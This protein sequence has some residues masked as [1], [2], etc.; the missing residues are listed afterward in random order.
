M[1]YADYTL[2]HQELLGEVLDDQLAYWRDALSGAPQELDLP[3][4]RP[5]PAVAGHQGGV[6]HFDLDAELHAQLDDLARRH[7]VTLFIVLQAGLA[8]LLSRLGAGSDIPLGTV[9]AG[10]SDEALDDLVGFFVNTLVLR[11]DVSGDPAFGE[12]LT[13]VRE[14]DLAAFAHQDVPFERLVEEIN[15]DRAAARHPLFQTMLVMENNAEGRLELPGVTAEPQWVDETRAKFDL[16]FTFTEERSSAGHPMGIRGELLF[17]TELFDRSSAQSM[18]DRLARLLTRAAADPAVPISSF[19]LLNAGEQRRIMSVWN[20]TDRVAPGVL[21]RALHEVFEEQAKRAPDATA[22]IFED[23]RVTYAELNERADRLV[24][25]LVDAGAVVGVRLERGVDMVVALLAV[26]KA[27]GGYTLLDPEFPAE[28]V[29]G[30]LAEAGVRTVL[31]RTGLS[32]ALT[33]FDVSAVCVDALPD[34]P[35]NTVVRDVCADDVAC[36]MFTSGSTGRPKGVATSHRALLGTYLG[37][38]YAD[39]GPDE[40]FLQCSP[41]S[42]DGFALELFGALLH[43]ATCVLQPGQSPEPIGIE[44]LVAEH[45]V[46]MLQLSA[47]LFNHL[48]DEYPDAFR[49]VRIAFTGGEAGSVAHVAKILQLFPDLHVGNGYGPVESMGFTTCHTITTDDLTG[50]QLPIGRPIGNKRAYV[51]DSGLHLL[52]AG[53]VGE[54]YVA[55]A[56]LAR[57]YVNRAGLTAER[58]VACPFGAPGERMYRTGDLA[59][60]TADGVLE[61]IGRADS[62][63][64][65]RGFRIEPGEIAATLTG[66]ESVVQAAVTAR[67]DQP[68]DVRLVAYAVPAEQQ[69]P[70]PAELRRYIAALL[71]RHMVPA[72][73]VL[74]DA[75]PLTSNGKLDSRALPAPQYAASAEGRQ[76]RTEQEQTLTGLFTEIL[77]VQDI[78]VDDSFFDLGGHSLLATR[79]ISRIR[80]TLGTELGIRDLFDAPTVAGLVQRLDGAATARTP[81]RIAERPDTLP[82]SSAQHRLWFLE[83]FEKQATYNAPFAYRLHGQVNLPALQAAI[84]D[85]I[86]RHEALRTTFPT[87]NGQPRQHILDMDA[88]YVNLAV[89]ECTE[90]QLAERI[91]ETAFTPFD[92]ESEVP[93]RATLLTLSNTTEPEPEPESVLVLALHHIASDG[94]SERPL[95]NDLTTAY[96]ARSTGNPPDWQ[97]LPVQYA[98]YTLWQRELLDEVL[99]DQLAYWAE[100]LSGA[101]QELALP[102]DR[103]RPAVAGHEGGLVEFALDA[104]LHTRLDDLAR[105][106]GATLFMVLQAALATLLSRMGAGSDIPLGTVVAGRSDEALDDLVGFFVNTLV[107]RTDTSGNPAFTELL[108]RVRDTDLGAFA[109]QDIP[110]ERLVEEINPDRTSSRHPLFQTMLVLQNNTEGELDLPGLTVEAEPFG[111]VP[112]KFDLDFTFVEDRNSSG[113]P[114]GIRGTVLFATSLFDRATAQLMADRLQLALEAATADPDSPI[115]SLQLFESVEAERACLARAEQTRSA[116][117]VAEAEDEAKAERSERPGARGPRSAQE[118]ILCGLFAEVLDTPVVGTDDNFFALG[119]HSLLA[120]RLISRIRTVLGAELGIRDLFRNPTVSGVAQRL[121]TATDDTR[122]ALTARVRPEVLPL[123]SAQHRLWFLERFE[124]QATYNAP[125]AYRLHGHIDVQALQAAVTDVVTRH[126][127][128]R[129]TFPTV[130]GEPQ[131]LVLDTE[132]LHVDFTVLECTEEQLAERIA[133]AAFAAFDLTTAI[134]IRIALLR[135]SESESMLVL[136]LHHIASD[137]WSERSLFEDLATAYRA[138]CAGEAPA[139]EPLPVQYADYTLWHEELLGEVLD[140]QLAYWRRTVS[141]MPQ[142]LDIPTDRPRP[143]VASH[144]GGLVEF[145][146]D[147]GLHA[148]LESLAR[149]HGV[150][151]FMVLQAGLAALLSRLGAGTDIPLGTVVAG[152]SDEALDDLVGFFVNTLVLRTDVSGDPAFTELLTRIRD[153]DLAAFTHQDIPFE[154]LVEEINPERS[155][156]RHPLFQVMLVLQNNAEG[157]IELDGLTVESESVGSIPAKFDLNFAFVEQ[158]DAAGLP[159]GIRGELLFAT[160]L[161]DQSSAQAMAD[162]LV[163]LLTG[164]ATDPEA[165]V[166]SA[167]LLG[168]D[169]RNTI[170]SVWNDTDRVAPG[171]LDRTLHEVFEEQARHAP[172]AVALVFGDERVT[173]AELNER[174]DRLVPWLVDAGAVIGIHLER[175]VDMVAALLAT[176][177]AGSGYT[178]LDPEFPAERVASVLSEADVPLVITRIGLHEAVSA[179]GTATVC[180]DALT[181]RPGTARIRDVCADDVACVMFTSGSTGRPKGVATS[182]G[183]LLGTYL[184]QDYADFGPDE[185]FLQCSPVSWDGF[186]LELFGALLHGATCVLQPGQSP[187]PIG[188]ERLVAEHGV[189]MLQLSASLFNHLVDEYPDAFRGVRIAFTGGEAGSVAHV[190]KILQLFPDLHVG[191]G[192]GPVES[193]GFTTCHTITTDDL[194]ASRLPIGRPVGNKRAYVLDSRLHPV[195]AGVVGEVYVAGAGLARGYVSRPGLTAERFVACPFGA[196]GERMYRTGDLARWTTDGTLEYIGRADDQIK[197]RGFR[198]EPGEIA[199]A[200]TGHEAV[201]QAAVIA[202]EDRPGDV[203]LVAYAVPAGH[204]TP[205]PEELRRYTAALLPRHMVPSAVVLLDALPLTSNGKLDRHALPAPEVR[206]EVGGRGPRSVREE[207]LCGIFAEVLSIPAVGVDDDFFVLGGHSLLA[208]R[209]ISR[210]RTTL[211]AELGIRDLFD[212]PTVAG[213]VQRLDGAAT[214]RTALRPTERP[215]TLPLSSAQHRLWFLERFEKQATYNAPFAYRLHGH[216]DLPALQA[217]INDVITRHEALRTTFPTTNGQPRQHVLSP[218]EAHLDLTVAECTEEQLAER[219]S[220]TAFTQFDLETEI[221]LRATLLTLSN[222]T[223]PEPEPESVLVLALHHIASD[224]WSERPLLNDLTTAYQARS[225]GNPPDWQPLPVQYADY[226]LWQRDLLTEIVDDQLA[227]WTKTLSGAPQELALP[228]DRPRPAA[229]SHE[230]GLV[231]FA[232]DADLHTRLDDLARRQGVTLF[233]V[234]QAGLAALLTRLGAGTDIPLGT[235]VAGRTDEALDDLVGFFVNTLVLRTDTSGNPAF[236]ELLARVRDTDLGA[237]AHQ[238]IPFERLVE[239]INPDRA[240]SRHPLFQTM[241][242]L[243]NNTEGTIGLDGLTLEAEPFGVGAPKFDLDFTFSEGRDSAGAPTGISGSVAFAADLFDRATARSM[244][245]RLRLILEGAAAD[246]DSPIGAV[247]LLGAG[248]RDR[249][250]T[251]WND[252]AR[253]LP[254]ARLLP[255]VFEGHARRAPGATALVADGTAVTFVELNARANRL[256]RLLLGTGVGPGDPVAVLLPRS[257]ELVVALLAVM[258]AGACYVPVDPEYPADRIG[259]M[260]ADAVP[261]VLLTDVRGAERLTPVPGEPTV[262][263]RL[264]H[265]SVRGAVSRQ[266]DGN[267]APGER[268]APLR[269]GDPAYIVYTS[270]STGRPKGVLVEHRA[271]TNLFHQH[272]GAVYADA[273]AVPGGRPLRAALTGATTFDAAWSPLLWMVAGHEL[274]LVDDETRRSP[275]ALVAY[276]A[277]A[278]IDYME[279]TPTYCRQLL[280]LGLLADDRPS[281]PSFL[282]IGG[283]AVDEALWSELGRASGT[284]TYNT[285]GPTECTVYT[286]YARVGGHERPV[287]GRPLGNHRAYVLDAGLGVVPAGVV[288][289]LYIAGAGLARGYVNR[290]GLTAERFVACPFGAPG[291]RM[292]RTGDL[293]RWTTDGVLEYIGRAD[294]QIKIRGFRIEPGEIAAALTGHQAVVQAAVIAREDRPGDVRLV[295]YAVPGQDTAPAVGAADL[296]RYLSG[297]LPRHMVPGAVVVLDALPM[298]PHGKLDH[299]ALPAPEAGGEPGGRGPRTVEERVLCEVFAEVL[300]IPAVGIDDDFFLL[301]GHS[302]KAAQLVS[303]ARTALGAE[304]GIRDLFDAPTVAGLAERL[305]AGGAV[306]SAHDPLSVLLPLRKGTNG[307]DDGGTAS[308]PLFCIHPAAGISWVYSGLLRHLDRSR[309]VYGLQARGLTDEA[310]APRSIEEMAEDYLA[311]IRSVQ[312]H[313]PYAL[314][315]WSF[316]GI[317]AHELAV[318]LQEEGEEVSALVLMDSYPNG[319]AGA[320]GALGAPSTPAAPAATGPDLPGLQDPRDPA[321]VRAVFESLGH[322]PD[323]AAEPGSPLALLGAGKL[324]AVTRVFTENAAMQDAF[325]PRTF[326]GD[327]LL[328]EATEGKP[329]GALRPDAWAA[330]V[331][332]RVHV[333]QVAGL[334]GELTRPVH[335]AGIGPVVAAWCGGE[336]QA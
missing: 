26:L 28:R 53:V 73:I 69:N 306:G 291:E 12:L 151:L 215:D 155:A 97:P 178:L 139:W 31:T 210:I 65:I 72:A 162:R 258:K 70:D 220:E 312:P 250:V 300:S 82:L 157:S 243:Q 229:P 222:T 310:A 267:L 283:E 152:R 294:D 96:Q 6:V 29:A 216:I 224:G 183:A 39:F 15:P 127:A 236:T 40:V 20:D 86:T 112:S 109:H 110:F 18:A 168:A 280:E 64:K 245:D 272:V 321:A 147:A 156:A 145:E 275:E 3:T 223:E 66:H 268:A 197:I 153:T 214:A 32:D 33:R 83:R 118:E 290:P 205:G 119:G 261:S 54:L 297:L 336:G 193:M 135:L 113:I 259:L 131:Q 58:F 277:A 295:A 56:G 128:L 199:A 55:G 102:T 1:Q 263:L 7:G 78:T 75:L 107:L 316:G 22:L 81:L 136:T 123:S 140:D 323:A 194:A 185:V 198:I 89:A 71:P 292:Y 307:G 203:R 37:Q 60:W 92:L 47:S 239:A 80:T 95:L 322:D 320:P 98:D 207:I 100:E 196:P 30:V 260:L 172:D 204:H 234:L 309:A 10:R 190:A 143:P 201:V 318:R 237:F 265:P 279:M 225:T 141:G 34:K 255:E 188:I 254:D 114:I 63:V 240:G 94:W 51:V 221:P 273:P 331:T 332:G 333:H 226:T 117:A 202:R 48:V 233:M 299:R 324:E 103:P 184:G 329:E 19:S 23:L 106:H 282:E 17:A 304:I 287:I 8:A 146:L 182:H 284:V 298:T 281:R 45:G 116:L 180:V 170:V 186:A 16:N 211:G 13:R 314:L 25:W 206:G 49:G 167:E 59:R 266:P 165:T 2:W 176:L 270:G 317:V 74:L 159:S 164:A 251:G 132:N 105:R 42:W 142:E 256:A 302:L 38:D 87:T 218:Q 271:L 154:R 208:T 330:H 21:G 335:L 213:L 179:L 209:L 144:E 232:L 288:G 77:G 269:P 252:T 149:R 174:A 35:S 125:F 61:Y 326:R 44:R 327:V 187:E 43:G 293:A 303:R 67:E 91:S 171:V 246:P 4:D 189:T 121:R 5:R 158:Q 115:G 301:G 163:R 264:D 166:G 41:V 328:I 242:V 175:G 228:T 230:G 88:A 200:L 212:A 122:T 160:D 217:A 305:A 111:S 313:G 50:T 227:Y 241:L 334:H 319:P 9:V 104:D 99:D 137:G 195:P 68:G 148:R 285:Y 177:K 36:V 173:Y 219:I 101:P 133:E 27:G 253:A 129:T 138:R 244:A 191:N 238:D 79:L 24:P 192:Y 57:G 93:L 276:A 84:N 120:T 62:Q 278:G 90:E 235:V 308:A 14:T 262:V 247:E 150:T 76:P 286:T 315:G 289:E 126:E 108:A 231:E 161:F 130:E 257:A 248:E 46:T 249:I 169:E 11:T 181:E 311:S 325:T 52:P 274:H 85:V 134:P 296:H 124:K